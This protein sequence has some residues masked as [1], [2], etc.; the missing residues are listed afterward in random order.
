[1]LF[2]VKVIFFSIKYSKTK[3]EKNN[4]SDNVLICSCVYTIREQKNKS[5]KFLKTGNTCEAVRA[6]IN[7]STKC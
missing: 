5:R 2:A 1:M 6:G 4:I 7:F 3:K